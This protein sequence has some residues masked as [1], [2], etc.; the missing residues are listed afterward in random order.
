MYQRFTYLLRAR[1]CTYVQHHIDFENRQSVPAI[2]VS[3]SC[4]VDEL[5]ETEDPKF[6]GQPS[7]RFVGSGLDLQSDNSSTRRWRIRALVHGSRPTRCRVFRHVAPRVGSGNI[8]SGKPEWHYFHKSIS[9]T[10]HLYLYVH[11]LSNNTQSD[12][13]TPSVFVE[14]TN[15]LN[16]P[17]LRLEKSI[18]PKATLA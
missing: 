13:T 11:S 15:N 5:V 10:L 4:V 7:T 6:L 1:G 3:L 8:F 18:H 14:D 17:F 2:G 9:T 12:H 16:S